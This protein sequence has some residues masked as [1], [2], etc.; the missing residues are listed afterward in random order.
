MVQTPKL[1]TTNRGTN[2]NIHAVTPK[3]RTTNKGTNSNALRLVKE[4][5]V[6]TKFVEHQH[7]F[8]NL[9]YI[10]AEFTSLL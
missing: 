8:T 10:E 6:A 9:Y 1:G 5:I 7:Y 2:S 4:P 3:S